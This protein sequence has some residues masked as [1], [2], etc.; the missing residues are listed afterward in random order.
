MI[1][2][3]ILGLVLLIPVL[4]IVLD[5]HLGR[6]L[7]A[8]IERGSAP[9]D[10]AALSGRIRELEGELERLSDEVVRLGEETRFTTQLLAERSGAARSLPESGETHA[11]DHLGP[12]PE[13]GGGPR[14][15]GA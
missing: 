3:L 7:A 9:S 5:S 8:R 15:G 11:S 1:T 2:V 12:E 13:N 10:A 14:S 4:A 6:A